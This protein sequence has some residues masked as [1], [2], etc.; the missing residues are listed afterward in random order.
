MQ[1]F[2]PAI[3]SRYDLEAIASHVGGRFE[4]EVVT[5]MQELLASIRPD[6]EVIG[7]EEVQF[8]GPD[9]VDQIEALVT[10]GKHVIVGGLDTDFRAEPFPPLPT[11]MAL[12]DSVTKLEAICMV[13]KGSASRTQRLVAGKPAPRNSP[14]IEVGAS[15]A[16]EARCRSCY[17]RPQ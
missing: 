12:A 5:T 2:K 8:F 9:T 6:T 11:L 3:D 1:V 16:Y 7:I 15:D 17:Q 14:L 13:C 10:S 4:A